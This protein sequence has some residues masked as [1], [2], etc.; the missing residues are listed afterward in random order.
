MRSVGGK[1]IMAPSETVCEYRR[2]GS[3]G[4]R[5]TERRWPA[6]VRV[7]SSEREWL[8]CESCADLLVRRLRS[9]GWKVRRKQLP[10]P[11]PMVR[12]R[13]DQG[14]KVK[15][16]RLSVD[17][18]PRLTD[19]L[20][21]QRWLDRALQSL[22]VSKLDQR[23]EGGALWVLAGAEFSDVARACRVHGIQFRYLASGGKAT[24]RQPGWFT[25]WPSR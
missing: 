11:V 8:V 23:S 9:E 14:R 7:A 13:S 4:N 21:V 1:G 24:N 18:G 16:A 5:V 10:W 20:D 2:C 22:G 3:V 6:R 12:T 19:E 25:R 15:E 17:A